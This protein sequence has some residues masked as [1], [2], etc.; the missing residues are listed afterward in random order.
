MNKTCFYKHGLRLLAIC[1]IACYFG[2]FTVQGQIG[3]PPLI[4]VQP[5]GISVSKG[6]TAIITVVA[7][8]LTT[9][10]Y[11]WRKTSG[12]GNLG[13]SAILTINNV[14]KSDE[15]LYY[16]KVKNSSG[17]T[18]SSNAVL[19]VIADIVTN[20][21]VN[22]TSSLMTPTGFRT[23][24]SVPTGSNCVLLASTDLKTWTPIATNTATSGGCTF[25]DAA[26]ADRPR[27]YY[28]TMLQ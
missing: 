17:T 4:I 10:S 23:S 19:L 3:G 20:V 8:S 11:D 6:G 24:W 13:N 15:G 25:T 5:L 28:K 16:V 2:T 1:L 18:I 26:A 12:S 27:C 21:V 9:M 7:A 14:K 22:V